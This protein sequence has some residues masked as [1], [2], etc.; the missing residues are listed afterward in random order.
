MPFVPFREYFGELAE[1]ETRTAK[2][3]KDTDGLPAGEYCFLESY[4]DEPGCDCR[5][6]MLY[7]VSLPRQRY[8][9]TIAF[10]W[11]SPEFYAKWMRDDDPETI[12]MLRGPVLNFGSPETELSPAVLELARST[13]FRD[14]GYV[15]RLQRHYSLMRAEVERRAGRAVRQAPR[16]G[17][18]TPCPCGSGRKFKKC[19]GDGASEPNWTAAPRRDAA[20]DPARGGRPPDATSQTGDA[21]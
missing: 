14:P 16:V 11:D 8:E 10:G 6:V 21:Q 15:A 5:R 13:L 18:N 3:F 4:C 17:R 2:L 20:Q 19:C 1:Q 9:A 7:V 12:A